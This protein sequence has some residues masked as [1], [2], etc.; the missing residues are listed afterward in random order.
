[1]GI[2][3]FVEGKSTITRYITITELSAT[4][5]K[6]S[7]ANRNDNQVLPQLQITTDGLTRFVPQSP[8]LPIKKLEK[9][10]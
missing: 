6:S 1:M 4:S 8:N 10:F 9:N 2:D 3:R 5:T 7:K